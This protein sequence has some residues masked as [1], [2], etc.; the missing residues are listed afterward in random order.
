M[1]VSTFPILVSGTPAPQLIW[2]KEG[3]LVD[4]GIDK[5]VVITETELKIGSLRQTDVGEYVCV[6]K[7]SQG[8]VSTSSKVIIAGPAVITSPPTNLTKLEGTH[9]EFI[10]EAKALPANITHR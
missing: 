2:E 7:N 3:Q 10:C 4:E 6:A 1:K 9:A 5:H 8:S